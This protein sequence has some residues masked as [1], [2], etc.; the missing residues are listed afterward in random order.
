MPTFTSR[1]DRPM[2]DRK[3]F[4]RADEAI[5]RTGLSGFALDRRLAAGEIPVF[6]DPLDRRHRLIDVQDLDRLVRV[7]RIGQDRVAIERAAS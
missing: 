5:K 7:V 3:Q 1:G 4:V 6:R 2:I